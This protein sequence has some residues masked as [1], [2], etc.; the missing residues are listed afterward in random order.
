MKVFYTFKLAV[1]PISNPWN[2]KHSYSWFDFHETWN[3]AYITKTKVI[4]NKK[5]VSHGAYPQILS[6]LILVRF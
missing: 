1:V 3:V 5:E 2:L 6:F 4:S